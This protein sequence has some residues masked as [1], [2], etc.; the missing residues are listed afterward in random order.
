MVKGTSAGET[1]V[2]GVNVQQKDRRPH[3]LYS[4]S[5]RMKSGNSGRSCFQPPFARYDALSASK[6]KLGSPSWIELFSTMAMLSP[7]GVSPAE[8]VSPAKIKSAVAAVLSEAIFS[9]EGALPTKV[10]LSA[11]IVLTAKRV[12]PT[13]KVLS[14]WRAGSDGEGDR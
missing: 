14:A 2:L 7:E 3:D 5:Q 10:L 12:F 6:C 13:G 8:A 9:T 4:I 1:S 11:D